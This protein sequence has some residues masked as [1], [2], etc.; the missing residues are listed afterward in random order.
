[1][2]PGNSGAVPGSEARLVGIL[3]PYTGQTFR[4]LSGEAVIGRE[5]GLHVSLPQEE[6]VSRRHAVLLQQGAG[7]I[8]R[9]EG[10]SNGTWVNGVRIQEQT[11]L[12]GDFVRLGQSEF[13][14]EMEMP[15]AVPA[16]P[17]PAAPAGFGTEAAPTATIP[18]IGNPS[19]FGG[20]P[21][22]APS[23][24]PS[25]GPAAIGQ[26]GAPG[27]AAP[28]S[29]TYNAPIADPTGY[30]T[31]PYGDRASSTA[32][33]VL[34]MGIASLLCNF[35][36]ICLP[37]ATALLPLATLGLGAYELNN[38]NSGK[39]SQKGKTYTLT[40]MGLAGLSLLLSIGMMIFS[41]ALRHR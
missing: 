38:I 41:F 26:P 1:M 40:G 37:F 17:Y 15:A 39:S 30:P 27:T 32:S 31:L 18:A 22:A 7:W 21:G 33:A 19:I 25:F 23:T 28:L 24:P 9:D 2:E 20:A 4:V 8:L 36:C 10:S 5:L 14:F 29:G 13:R 12:P 16:S 3:G 6:T 35:A 11:L 34:G